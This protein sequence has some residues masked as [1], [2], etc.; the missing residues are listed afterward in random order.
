MAGLDPAIHVLSSRCGKD[1]DAR[2][3]RLRFSFAGSSVL[4][5]RS[6]GEGGSPGM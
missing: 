6:L 2:D 5:R 3:T 4:V 1:M